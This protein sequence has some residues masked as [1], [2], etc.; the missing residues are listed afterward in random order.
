MRRAGKHSHE[1]ETYE[2][3]IAITASLKHEG[4]TGA[5]DWSND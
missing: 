4:G 1:A 3:V 5:A 2:T